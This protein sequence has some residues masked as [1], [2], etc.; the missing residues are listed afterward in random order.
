M[1]SG[2]PALAAEPAGRIGRLSGEAVVLR[3]GVLAPLGV[4]GAIFSRDHLSTTAGG[5]VEA[6][7]ADGT[8]I[9]LAEESEVVI[10]AWR[11][12][13]EA[14]DGRLFLRL[15]SGAIKLAAGRLAEL[16]G[17]QLRLRTPVATVGVRGT[18][19]W[20]GPMEGRFGVLLLE[21]GVSVENTSGR[22]ELSAPGTGV[23][24]AVPEGPPP[25]ELAEPADAW[26]GP[27]APPASGGPLSEPEAWASDRVA[28]ALD[29]VSF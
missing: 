25:P 21:G 29:A 26:I 9:T 14:G 2:P 12:D 10:D 22:V 1:G 24:I 4:G 23:F 13:F 7:F 8:S 17:E 16:P 20:A 3:A 6:I 18:R 5:R 15:V 28:R 11:L 27:G 19:F